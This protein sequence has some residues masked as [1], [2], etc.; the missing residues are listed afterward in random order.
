MFEKPYAKQWTHQLWSSGNQRQLD[1][2]LI[3]SGLRG[4]LKD[5]SANGDLDFKS[6]HRC[7]HVE[8]LV[9]DVS[10]KRARK[11]GRRKN[12]REPRL[13][14]FHEALDAALGE[15]PAS[16]V[17]LADKVVAAAR[18]SC[19][20]QEVVQTVVTSRHSQALLDLIAARRLAGNPQQRKETT[21]MIWVCLKEERRDRKSRKLDQLLESNKSKSDL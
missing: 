15:P 6:D 16:C 12:M 9:Q 8:L 18:L 17:E 2:I 3:S 14:Q 1:Y 5:A 11:N 13:E 21:K 20:D 19:D 7:I 4:A 10:R